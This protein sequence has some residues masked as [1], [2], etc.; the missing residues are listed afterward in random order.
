MEGSELNGTMMMNPTNFS[1]K[2]AVQYK[3]IHI[4]SKNRLSGAVICFVDI[5]KT[6]KLKSLFFDLLR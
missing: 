1:G 3:K 4:L 6:N 2:Y 5:K